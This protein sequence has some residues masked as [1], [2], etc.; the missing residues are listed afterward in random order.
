MQICES[1]EGGMKPPYFTTFIL[2]L[3]VFVEFSKQKLKNA[4]EK[5]YGLPI[6]LP[7]F[8]NVRKIPKSKFCSKEDWNVFG[9]WVYQCNA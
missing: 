8:V 5:W 7:N 6:K 4:V 3:T 1:Y 2:N 9:L